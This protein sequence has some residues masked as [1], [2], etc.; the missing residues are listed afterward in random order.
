MKPIHRKLR[1]LAAPYLD[2]RHNDVH[3][4]SSTEFAYKLLELEGGDEDVVIPAIILHD[5]GWKMVSEDMQL[6]AFGPNAVYPDLNRVHEV[7]G[8]K[9]AE[10]ILREVGYDES[11]TPEIV[12]IIEGHDSRLE[13]ISHNDKIVKDSDKLYRYTN[14]AFRTNMKRFHYSADQYM[15]RLRK[16]LPIWLIT[17]SGKKLAKEQLNE[18]EREMKALVFKAV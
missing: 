8:A 7:E 17:D 3:T 1:E 16:H 4:D 15:E 9:I 18:R 10:K 13:P 5:V 14:D 12:E 2:T 6:K 11:R